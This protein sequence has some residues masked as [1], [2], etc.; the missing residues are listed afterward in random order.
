M[1]RKLHVHNQLL[2]PN[3]PTD[4][5]ILSF[6]R[7]IKRRSLLPEFVRCYVQFLCPSIKT[8]R[9]GGELSLTNW[10]PC[11]YGIPEAEERPPLE[12]AIKQRGREH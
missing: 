3:T 2:S 7:I 8:E 6:Q 1:F 10:S 11:E 4:Y 12:A 9:W 5:R